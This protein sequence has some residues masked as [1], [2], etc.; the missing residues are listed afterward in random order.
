M[1]A[2]LGISDVMG[3]ELAVA[4]TVCCITQGARLDVFPVVTSLCAL[5]E[6]VWLTMANPTAT[7]TTATRAQGVLLR[8]TPPPK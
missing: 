8:M 4:C 5:A 6:G 7:E 1:Q 2:G 3:V